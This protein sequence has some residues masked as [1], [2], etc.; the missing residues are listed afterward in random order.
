MSH[1]GDFRAGTTLHLY[2]NSR[3]TT[4][5]PAS[6]G[7]SPTSLVVYK[8]NSTT[9]SVAGVTFTGNFDG[10]TGLNLVSIDTSSD[11][12]FY[13]VGSRFMVALDNGVVGGISVV[14]GVVAEFTLSP[15]AFGRDGLVV[16]SVASGATNSVIPISLQFPVTSETTNDHFNGRYVTFVTGALA[17]QSSDITDYFGAGQELTVTALTEAPNQGDKFV[18]S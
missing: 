14:G 5:A 8:D 3:D 15:I 1:R 12:A 6:L 7:G 2:F 16:G 17:G 9:Q 10:V 18:I 4:G 11:T 13:T